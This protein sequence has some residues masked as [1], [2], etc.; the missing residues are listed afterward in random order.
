MLARWR[1]L[2]NLVAAVVV[3]AL[4]ADTMSVRGEAAPVAVLLLFPVCG[5][6]SLCGAFAAGSMGRREQIYDAVAA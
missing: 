5:G 2:L 1:L 4:M 6:A 3:I